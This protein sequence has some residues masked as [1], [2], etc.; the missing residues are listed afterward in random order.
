MLLTGSR[1]EAFKTGLL[2]AEVAPRIDAKSSVSPSPE[3]FT[4]SA[5][6][7]CGREAVP[8]TAIAGAAVVS[9]T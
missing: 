6:V 9:L 8:R 7:W 3:V 4:P 1:G 2:S 5:A